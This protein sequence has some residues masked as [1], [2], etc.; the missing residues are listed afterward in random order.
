MDHEPAVAEV[1]AEFS[2]SPKVVEAA[3]TKYRTDAPDLLF[4]MR[5]GPFTS[6]EIAFIR[7][8]CGDDNA[9]R[10]RL[11]LLNARKER[12]VGEGSLTC[13]SCGLAD[14]QM[15]LPPPTPENIAGCFEHTCPCGITHRLMSKQLKQE[16]AKLRRLMRF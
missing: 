14:Q 4:I 1:A 5:D 12:V 8:I 7:K 2:R 16:C 11:P 13:I 9:E 10:R 3:W 15:W 6:S